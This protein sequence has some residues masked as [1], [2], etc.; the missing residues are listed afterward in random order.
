M[1]M[2][3]FT[4][5]LTNRWLTLSFSCHAHTFLTR[6]SLAAMAGSVR[7]PRLFAYSLSRMSRRNL[8]ALALAVGAT[9]A[10]A[11]VVHIATAPKDTLLQKLE[12]LDDAEGELPVEEPAM[13]AP[14]GDTDPEVVYSAYQPVYGRCKK[15]VNMPQFSELIAKSCG[16]I[17]EYSDV[18]Y[19]CV[20]A[21]AQESSR[22]GCCWETVMEG[23]QTLYPQAYHAWRMWQGTL[24]GKTGVTFDDDSCGEST[25]E[26]PFSDLKDEVG[27]L[28]DVIQQQQYDIA[29]LEAQVRKCALRLP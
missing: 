27:Q 16:N 15:V 22:M 13:E 11:M 14:L 9:L 10:M 24:S 29:Y 5:L 28:E 25:G 6:V 17:H 1:P 12:E 18:A 3:E 4:H 2:T 26:K 23:Y 19:P 21:M 8:Q 20:Q 7:A